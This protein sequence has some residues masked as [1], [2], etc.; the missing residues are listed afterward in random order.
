[1]V[2]PSVVLHAYAGYIQDVHM[3]QLN[4][5]LQIPI[6]LAELG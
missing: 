4:N 1:M 2:S 6:L 5:K 3:R